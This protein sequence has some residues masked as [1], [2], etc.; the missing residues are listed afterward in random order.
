MKLLLLEEWDSSPNKSYGLSR[1]RELAIRNEIVT[2]V[3]FYGGIMLSV[4]RKTVSKAI[5]IFH[6]Y[7]KQVPY[8]KFDRFLYAAACIFL[9]AK[10]DDCPR[11]LNACCNAYLYCMKSRKSKKIDFTKP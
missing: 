4:N 9:T 11:Q 8:K 3:N 7:S 5:L 2:F 1:E 10:L 6:R